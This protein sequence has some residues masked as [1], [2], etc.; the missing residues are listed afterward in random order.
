MLHLSPWCAAGKHYHTQHSQ[1]MNKRA[2]LWDNWGVFMLAI[3]VAL[4]MLYLVSRQLHN[5][6]SP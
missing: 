2:K 4:L 5:A 6:F 1:T 3:A